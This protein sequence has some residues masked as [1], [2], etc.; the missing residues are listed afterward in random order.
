MNAHPDSANNR[1]SKK[2]DASSGDRRPPSRLPPRENGLRARRDES[3]RFWKRVRYS[4][5]FWNPNP[6]R[7][8]TEPSNA[9]AAEWRPLPNCCSDTDIPLSID[10]RLR[11]N[12]PLFS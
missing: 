9:R 8:A 2:E 5:L 6:V 3:A 1:I 4:R 7:F 10:G 12:V 11:I